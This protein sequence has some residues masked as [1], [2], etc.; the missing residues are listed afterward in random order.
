M[1]RTVCVIGAGP[2]GLMAAGTA[3]RSGCR[4]VL[5]EKNAA[6]GRKLLLTGNGRCN[7]TNNCGLQ[8]FM[9]NVVR[10]RRFL[11]SALSAFPP[12][13]VMDF[14]EGRGVP[15]KTEQ[16]GRVFPVSDRAAD[17]RD[18]LRA[19][20]LES[21]AELRRGQAQEILAENGAVSGVGLKGGEAIRC[22][23][24]VLATGGLSYPKTGSTGDGYRMAAA[25]SHTVIDTR[26]SLVP[27]LADE[28]WC[29]ELSGLTLKD[30]AV[31]VTD[32]RAGKTVFKGSG[33][34]LFT[35]TGLSGPVIFSASAHMEDDAPG[36]YRVAIDLKPA[37]DADALDR[38]IL[39]GFAAAKNR[40]LKNSLNALLP[41]SLIPVI[42]RL[43][44]INPDIKTNAVT[45]AERAA[46]CG[47]L[48]AL[49]VTVRG[50]CPIE[51]AVVTRGGVC[52][53][54]VNPGTMESK[55]CRG[56]YFAGEILDADA[57]T[58]GFNLQIAFSTGYIAGAAAAKGA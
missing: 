16:G 45:R 41:K 43:S 23:A 15:L 6:P 9:E 53:R 18:A 34:L 32:T 36:R 21:G 47:L 17:I 50:L 54:E 1:S 22:D 31:K 7:V 14:F 19:F 29:A 51:E 39:R 3:A 2:A 48:K 4:T 27:L 49:P 30:C 11:Y 44:G 52:V 37:L 55:L 38:C 25:L 46:L 28:A 56:L 12:Q 42:I 5:L 40:D 35:R 26:P 13:N 8:T 57:Y 24:A 58:G 20:A 10:N 33:E